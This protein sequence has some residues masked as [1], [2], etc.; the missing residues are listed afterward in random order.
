MHRS[1]GGNASSVTVI[2]VESFAETF[3]CAIPDRLLDLGF[4]WIFTA[5]AFR[6]APK[7]ISA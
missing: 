6:V 2:A 1:A 5:G 4:E 3:A 7:R